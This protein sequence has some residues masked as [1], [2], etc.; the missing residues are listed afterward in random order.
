M[1]GGTNGA[2]VGIDDEGVGP[3]A[4]GGVGPGIALLPLVCHFFAG[5]PPLGLVGRADMA[6]VGFKAK[7]LCVF[8][9]SGTLLTMEKAYSSRPEALQSI[10]EMGKREALLSNST[11]YKPSLQCCFRF[12]K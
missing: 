4:E 8:A 11:H 7:V 2:G 9:S 5:I 12:P 10:K 1:E 6:W 3:E